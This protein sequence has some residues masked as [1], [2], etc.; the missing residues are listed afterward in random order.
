MRLRPTRHKEPEAR[1]TSVETPAS[2]AIL[3]V[4]TGKYGAEDFY[5]SESLVQD[6]L[7]LRLRG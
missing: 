5:F 4:V 7:G 6:D 1:V 2:D 3:R